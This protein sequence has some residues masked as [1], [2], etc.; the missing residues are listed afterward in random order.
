MKGR[1][2]KKEIIKGTN[3]QFSFSEVKKMSFCVMEI[4]L[5]FLL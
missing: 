1:N 3:I 4:M 2:L 5:T